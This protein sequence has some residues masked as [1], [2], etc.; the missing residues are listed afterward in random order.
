MEEEWVWGLGGW[1]TGGDRTRPKGMRQAI[2]K[3][4]AVRTGNS[5]HH[6]NFEDQF[7]GDSLKNG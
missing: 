7:R 1:E 5:S 2:R 3:R 6:T 4:E